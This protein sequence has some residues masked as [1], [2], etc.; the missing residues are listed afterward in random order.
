MKLLFVDCCISQRGPASRTL[1]LA[2]AYSKAF[3]EKWPDAEIETVL[4]ET[5]LAALVEAGKWQT[6]EIR[7]ASVT[8]SLDIRRENHYNAT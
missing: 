6:S 2:S 7:V 4:P 8:S 5:L 3:L 1:L